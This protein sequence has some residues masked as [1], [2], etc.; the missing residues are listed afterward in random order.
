MGIPLAFCGLLRKSP[1]T[2]KLM[3]SISGMVRLLF[4]R[5]H[6]KKLMNLSKHRIRMNLNLIVHL[7]IA[8]SYHLLKKFQILTHGKRSRFY[9][10]MII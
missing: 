4:L 2:S 3:T 10:V 8:K 9:Q 7:S 6:P 5:K 1:A